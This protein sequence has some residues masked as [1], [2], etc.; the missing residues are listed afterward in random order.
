MQGGRERRARRR[1]ATQRAQAG[2]FGRL[3]VERVIRQDGP[4]HLER[5]QHAVRRLAIELR[6]RSLAP[7][8]HAILI[9]QP[10]HDGAIRRLSAPRDDERM[11]GGE[12]E[13]LGFESQRHR[14]LRQR[15]VQ[16]RAVRWAMAPS[17]R[18][19]GM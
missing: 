19:A 3:H 7:P 4:V 6:R 10:H 14:G 1:I 16:L 17:A 5:R 11:A 15:S 8:F 2:E 9:H 13:D 18:R 12:F